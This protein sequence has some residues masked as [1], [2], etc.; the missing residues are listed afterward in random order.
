MVYKL[1]FIEIGTK[2]PKLLSFVILLNLIIVILP[3]L[4]ALHGFEINVLFDNQS[5]GLRKKIDMALDL[6]MKRY[7][8][9]KIWLIYSIDSFCI[10]DEAPENE[11]FI[12][13]GIILEQLIYNKVNQEHK[14]T[15]NIRKF[16]QETSLVQDKLTRNTS[17]KQMLPD[18]RK[19]KLAVILDYSLE[20]GNPCL[21]QVQLQSM[22]QAFFQDNRTIFWLGDEPS[23]T[24]L[25]WLIYQFHVTQHTKLKQQIIEAI[26]AHVSN[27]PVV[28]FLKQVAF[29]DGSLSL[30]IEAIRWLGQ[31]HSMESIQLLTFLAIKNKDIVLRKK[32]IFAL[33]QIDDKTAKNVVSTLARKEENLEVRQ[34]AIFWLSQIADDDA[35]KTLNEILTSDKNLAIKEYAIFAISQLPESKAIPILLQAARNNPDAQIRKKAKFWLTRTRNQRMMDFFIDLVEQ[36]DGV[37]SN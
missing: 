5:M 31:H 6:A 3:I 33:S 15:N 37:G 28:E 25:S 10:F 26:S 24:S 32:A 12:Q 9:Q 30:K 19:G 8:G 23:E 13:S 18:Q 21:Y 35:L 20:S 11:K 29:G 16:E 14:K 27:Q 7:D 4:G 36:K 22:S 34:E 1:K 17:I 2:I